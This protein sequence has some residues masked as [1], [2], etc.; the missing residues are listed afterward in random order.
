[1]KKKIIL[2]AV[3]VIAVAA[4]VYLYAMYKPHRDIT[5]ETADFT[6]SVKQLQE[7]YAKN[8]TMFNKKYMDK[9]IE[10][11]GVVSTIDDAENGIVI[12]EKLSVTFNDS[13][14]K[15]IAVGKSIKIKGRLLTYDDILE[16]FKMDQASVIK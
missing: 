2:I 8:D 11:K 10:V 1:M 15:E 14:K 7:E 4:S 3:F 6:V 12:D 5:A 16:E 13:T 9:T